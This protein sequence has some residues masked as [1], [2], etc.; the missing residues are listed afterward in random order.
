MPFLFCY[1]FI[2]MHWLILLASNMLLGI[3]CSAT[4]D[5]ALRISNAF[6]V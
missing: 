3:V 2:L 5:A 4:Q 1:L 6:H